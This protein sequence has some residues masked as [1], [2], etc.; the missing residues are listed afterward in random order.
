VTAAEGDS[1]KGLGVGPVLG[2]VGLVA[3]LAGVVLI[4]RPSLGSNTG[5]GYGFVTLLGLGILAVGLRYW[6]GL[7]V[8]PIK[9]TTTPPDVEDRTTVS[10]P[11]VAF[12]RMIGDPRIASV[13]QLRNRREVVDRL[14]GVAEELLADG[15]GDPAERL[16]DGSWTD[17]EDA[18]ALFDDTDREVGLTDR[19]SRATVGDT[20]FT[21]R[22]SA[23]VAELAARDDGAA[24]AVEPNV[25]EGTGSVRA[26]RPA[27]R[28]TNRWRLLKPMGLTAVGVGVVFG[29]AGLLLGGALLGGFGAYAAAGSP[30]PSSVRVSRSI[31]PVEPAPGGTVRVTVEVENAGERFLPD[32]RVVDRVPDGLSVTAGSP[33]HGTALR[34]G[35]TAT[36]DYR[37]E[38]VRGDHAF[39]DAY[40][41]SRNL[42]GSLE[43][44]TDVPVDGDASI[45][46]DVTAVADRPVPLRK[47]ASRS[48]GR[49]MTD[50]GGSGIEF[51]SVREYRTGDPLKR[52]DWNRAAAGQ[53]LA[54]LQFREER[55]ATVVVLVDARR[56]AYV[57]P[58]SDAP[59]AVDRG[60]LAASEAVSALLNAD[61]RVGLAALS[62]RRCW[63]EPGAGHAHRA[64]IQEVLAN[65]VAFD[66][67]PPTQSFKPAIRLRRLR[68]RLPADAQLLVFS[69]VCDDEVVDIVRRLQAGGHP[70]TVI[71]PNATGGETPGRTLA[72]I[73]RGL[74]LSTLR[75]AGVRVVDWDAEEPL[76][77]AL[78]EAERR[79]SA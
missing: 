38:A 18:A 66:P 24:V 6:A 34:P 49:V 39:G 59:S 64:R 51:H 12:D 31:E 7:V 27:L 65:T 45:T 75:E 58:E 3:V 28:A 73:E 44:V 76:A 68:K 79:W 32:L 60:V 54:T 13:S 47:Q 48:V 56:E 35:A 41:V 40:V 21:R 53:D 57:T 22:V 25:P 5:I 78:T 67:R 77:L 62:P 52:I 71:S 8:T 36:Y 46:Y 63:I 69:P 11:G 15:D 19:L 50:V 33:R 14:R 29:S 23:A 10:V 17:D 42:S 55:S 72:R 70:T 1:T 61:D 9:R 4:V 43:R 16:A 74:R 30:P 26:S 2:V 37:V 20:T